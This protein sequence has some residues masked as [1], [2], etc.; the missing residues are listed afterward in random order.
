[1]TLIKQALKTLTVIAL[2]SSAT[3]F[4][5]DLLVDTS[6]DDSFDPGSGG[7]RFDIERM[8]VQWAADETITVDVYTNFVDY[9][10]R[11]STYD[12]DGD[13]TGNIVLGDLLMSTDG[14]DT[15]YN[16]AFVLSDSVR[17]SYYSS[18]RGDYWERTGNFTEISSTITSEEYH[19]DSVNVSSGTVL[20][21]ETVGAG[22]EGDLTIN[23]INA[24][25]NFDIISFSFNVN[26]ISAFQ[27]A[28]Q[29][30]FS[31]AMSCANDV[32]EGVVSVNRPGSNSIPEP[33]TM[34]LML[35]ALGFMA[36]SRKK[37]DNSVS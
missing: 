17:E 23:R 16:Y 20:A 12:S 28:E 15:P 31:W 5:S 25:D 3:A 14:G 36:N 7:W 2:F 30:A 13:F 4:A 10:N 19:D 21:G 6:I 37:A 26:G 9:N 27:T 11:Y 33:A 32:V 35:L 1:M 18:S 22:R 24:S 8:D 29:V 34:L